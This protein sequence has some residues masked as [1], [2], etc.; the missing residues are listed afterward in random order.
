L[1][2]LLHLLISAVAALSVLLLHTQLPRS[3]VGR[4]F[5]NSFGLGVSDGSG[6]LYEEPMIRLERV[7]QRLTH[8]A[9]Q[10][11]SIG[12]LDGSWSG[13]PSGFRIHPSTVSTDDLRPR[14]LSKPAGY[15]LGFAIRK[16]VDNLLR[17][18]ITQYGS[19][20]VTF[21]PGPVVDAKHAR[22]LDWSG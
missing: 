17:L 16:Q 11:P 13:L 20:A 5:R 4:H 18:Q 1:H 10:V 19:I 2:E 21:S 6:C 22:S 15:G 8:V 12:D 9:Q 7:L 14:V 3:S